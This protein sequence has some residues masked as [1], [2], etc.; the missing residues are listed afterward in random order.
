[1]SLTERVQKDMVQAMK[2]G[3]RERV[4]AL[5]MILSPLQLAGKE[6]PGPFGEEEER[7]VLMAEKKRR[8][9]AADAYRKGGREDR[10]G[11]EDAEAAIIDDYLPKPLSDEELSAMIDAAVAEIDPEGMKDMGRVMSAVMGRAEGRADGKRLSELVRQR[12]S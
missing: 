11:K 2:D 1:M 3:D 7:A 12:L 8:Q 9:Q 5:R 4:S 10:A 6:A